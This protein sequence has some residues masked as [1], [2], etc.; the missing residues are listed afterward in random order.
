MLVQVKRCHVVRLSKDFIIFMSI[1]KT[2]F[3]FS[4]SWTLIA[5]F[6]WI[7][8]NQILGSGYMIDMIMKRIL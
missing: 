7:C 1:F 3:L 2:H 6:V 8:M 4:L 5:L